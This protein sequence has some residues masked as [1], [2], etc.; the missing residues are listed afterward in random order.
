MTTMAEATTNVAK[1]RH[2]ITWTKIYVETTQVTVKDY[3]RNAISNTKQPQTMNKF[4]EL[5]NHFAEL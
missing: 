4:N 2:T 3:L 1:M 5:V